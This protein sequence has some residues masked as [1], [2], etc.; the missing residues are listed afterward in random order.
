MKD[1]KRKN[2]I[3]TILLVVFAGIFLYSAYQLGSYYL[4]GRRYR[5]NMKQLSEE[6]GGGIAES[7]KELEESLRV[8]RDRLVFPDEKEHELVAYVSN[9]T[10]E[11]PDQWREQ[12][13]VLV[14][15]NRDCIGYI[16]I[17]DT[18]LSYPVMFTPS[19]YDYY[20]DRGFEKK[21]DA[22]GVPFMDA[23][24][25]IGL[26]RNYIIYG[27]DM[28]DGTSFGLLR[29]FKK[30]EFAEAHPYVYFNTSVSAGVYQLMYVCRSKIY[31]KDADVFKYYKY[32][33]VL[34]EEQFN[35]YV[36]EMRARALF[37]SGVEAQWGDELLSLSTC[38]HYV[39][40]GRLILVYKRIR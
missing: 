31:A 36:K 11:V 6:I 3:Y 14:S 38:D 9:F 33:G 26:S 15:K 25:K 12:Y 19:R 30:K 32:G 20:L 37:V 24:T 23:A 39:E 7:T 34:S 29:D 22:R 28:R 17:P 8:N 10:E 35:T 27:H 16:E 1:G 2:L 18:I 13:S 5:K 21:Y 40:D 4:Q